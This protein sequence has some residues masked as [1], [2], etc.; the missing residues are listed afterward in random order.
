MSDLD[1]LLSYDPL[2]ICCSDA[3]ETE[4]IAADYS[5]VEKPLEFV[6]D[7]SNIVPA[8]A[9]AVLFEVGLP[10]ASF[11]SWEFEKCCQSAFS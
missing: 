10:A 6:E 3:W 4:G 11:V 5:L 7:Q 9:V 2:E 8:D 1:L